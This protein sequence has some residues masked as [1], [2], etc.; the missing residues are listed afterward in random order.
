LKRLLWVTLM[1]PD[2]Y[3]LL[4]GTVYR[5]YNTYVY[6]DIVKRYIVHI[7]PGNMVRRDEI[8]NWDFTLNYMIRGNGT[9]KKLNRFEYFKFEQV[10]DVYERC[11]H[12]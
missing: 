3:E 5:V 10:R 12:T 9:Y 1:K 7:Y 4:G 2:F 8:R 11:F 6:Y